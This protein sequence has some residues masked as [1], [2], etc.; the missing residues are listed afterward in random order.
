MK[1]KS[2]QQPKLLKRTYTC[3]K[4][5]NKWDQTLGTSFITSTIP[6]CPNCTAK[7]KYISVQETKINQFKIDN[8]T[9][10]EFGR[11]DNEEIIKESKKIFKKGVVEQEG[12]EIKGIK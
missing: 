5:G 12:V 4:C 8:P 11:A 1:F 3:R 2:N 6:D 7:S 10:K 9:G